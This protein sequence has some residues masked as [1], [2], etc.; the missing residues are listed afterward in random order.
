[1]ESNTVPSLKTQLDESHNFLPSPELKITTD[2]NFSRLFWRQFMHYGSGS[3]Q[4]GAL[5]VVVND[6]EHGRC[7][8]WEQTR[9]EFTGF[10]SIA[11]L[12]NVCYVLLARQNAP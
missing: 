1:M 7:Y 5:P 6:H 11:L 4:I 9:S 12:T 8:T 10:V 3:T 2:I